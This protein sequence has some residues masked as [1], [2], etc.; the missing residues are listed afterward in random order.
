MRNLY[1]GP[2]TKIIVTN[3]KLQP[4]IFP[5]KVHMAEKITVTIMSVNAYAGGLLKN[6]NFT[7]GS[8]CCC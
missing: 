1:I 3:L 5:A 6:V 2:D 7:T 4:Y 8:C